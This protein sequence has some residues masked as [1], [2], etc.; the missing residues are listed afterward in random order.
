MRIFAPVLVK[1][2]QTQLI[3]PLFA[4]RSAGAFPD[5][6]S[7]TINPINGMLS[8]PILS[9]FGIALQFV[10]SKRQCKF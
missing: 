5:I 9:A 10:E 4:D 3:D 6:L 1:H 2:V 8:E 7:C